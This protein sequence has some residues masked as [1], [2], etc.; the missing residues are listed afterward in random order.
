M[1]PTEY[2]IDLILYYNY[3]GCRDTRIT[4]VLFCHESLYSLEFETQDELTDRILFDSAQFYRQKAKKVFSV[5]K[6]NICSKEVKFKF[7]NALISHIKTVTNVPGSI[8]KWTFIITEFELIRE[9]CEKNNCRFYLS[10]N[11]NI[12]AQNMML[13]ASKDEDRNLHK[14]HMVNLQDKQIEIGFDEDIK[15]AFVDV[16]KEE[17]D[18][19]SYI[20]KLISFFYGVE[21]NYWLTIS[22][23]DEME[24]YSYRTILCQQIEQIDMTPWFLYKIVGFSKFGLADFITHSY[25][26]LLEVSERERDFIIK[27]LTT[28]TAIRNNSVVDKFIRLV[29]IL[30]TLDEKIHSSAI[31]DGAVCVRHIYNEFGID[32]DR[33]D[34]EENRLLNKKFIM[35]KNPSEHS[36]QEDSNLNDEKT[37]SNFV[38]LRHEVMH[39]LPSDEIVSYLKESLLLTRLEISVFIVILGELGFRNLEFIYRFPQ[40]N[41]L[42]P[43]IA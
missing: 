41:V 3:N 5:N 7:N 33:I 31:R 35:Q 32:F 2:T 25:A 21:I 11:H 43:R 16:P 22:T 39:A 23:V 38:E 9:Q 4:A 40:L 14:P 17:K 28:F 19:I 26:K 18:S 34:D 15:Y 1:F 37:I 30:I 10:E 42:K 8:T 13:I 6:A 29:S 36:S 20:V 27:S 24:I 12:L